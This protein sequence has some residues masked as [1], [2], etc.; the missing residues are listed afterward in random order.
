[1]LTFHVLTLRRTILDRA[2]SPV[3]AEAL[4]SVI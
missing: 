1:M 4:A 2:P 3:G